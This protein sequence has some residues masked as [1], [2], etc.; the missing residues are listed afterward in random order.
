MYYYCCECMHR[1]NNS[2]YYDAA[3]T[4]TITFEWWKYLV[5]GNGEWSLDRRH[6]VDIFKRN[7]NFIILIVIEYLSVLL[8]CWSYTWM[9]LNLGSREREGGNGVSFRF[10]YL[11]NYANVCD[12]ITCTMWVWQS[13][14]SLNGTVNWRKKQWCK[15]YWEN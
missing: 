12:T 4:T 14:Q 7:F 8:G 15:I 13:I 9:G 6:Y 11:C 1:D 2:R 5:M 10:Y 3:T